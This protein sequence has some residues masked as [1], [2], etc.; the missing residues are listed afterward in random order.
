MCEHHS[1][2]VERGTIMI[3]FSLTRTC[4]M[5]ED[6]MCIPTF[7]APL[8]IRR[9]LYWLRTFP[10]IPGHDY[11][12]AMFPVRVF[13][14]YVSNWNMQLLLLLKSGGGANL[15]FWGEGGGRHGP[16]LWLLALQGSIQ[17]KA[18]PTPPLTK[19]CRSV[20]AI[21]CK[22]IYFPTLQN[23]NSTHQYLSSLLQDLPGTGVVATVAV[24]G[25]AAVNTIKE[26]YVI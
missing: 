26:S 4:I 7:M 1:F 21:I 17:G 25:I 9:L 13:V 11:T 23:S 20:P 5:L 24:V 3:I 8:K 6:I 12:V 18:P 22:K 16:Q 19:S 10:S 2:S 14:L 15:M